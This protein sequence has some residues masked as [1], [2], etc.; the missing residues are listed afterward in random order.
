M[1]SGSFRGLLS[2][3]PTL[4]PGNGLSQAMLLRRSQ[5]MRVALVAVGF[6]RAGYPVAI[7]DERMSV[8]RPD[9]HPTRYRASAR[10]LGVRKWIVP[11]A[12]PSAC[13]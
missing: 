2:R 13:R 1:T 6:S 8:P 11:C 9:A 4:K 5:F 10:Q 3:G 12:R 7:Q